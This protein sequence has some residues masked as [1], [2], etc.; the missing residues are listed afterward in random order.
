MHKIS[1]S[2]CEELS[3]GQ[4]PLGPSLVSKGPATYTQCI[5]HLHCQTHLGDPISK[6]TTNTGDFLSNVGVW[7][8]PM[9]LLEVGFDWDSVQ[10]VGGNLIFLC[11]HY[12]CIGLE[13][14]SR[15]C[16]V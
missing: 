3:T 8:A 9:T 11:V 16:I 13:C 10:V 2:V 1:T 5:C 14:M 6:T 7:S 12:S 4:L 15:C